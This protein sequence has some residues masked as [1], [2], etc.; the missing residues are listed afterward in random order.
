MTV[1]GLSGAT[2]LAANG[3]DTCA[4]LSSGTVKCWGRNGLDVPGV[5][6]GPWLTPVAIQDINGATA[7]AGGAA[8]C[9]VVAGGMARCWGQNDHGQLGDGTTNSSRSLSTVPG[10][11]GV[12]SVAAGGQHTCAL[13][14]DHSVKCWGDNLSGELGDGAPLGNT[15]NPPAPPVTVVGL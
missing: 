7:L 5:A 10:L 14:S 11:S 13:L 3:T 2:T 15:I 12:V 9:V 6:R 4:L 1:V 8:M